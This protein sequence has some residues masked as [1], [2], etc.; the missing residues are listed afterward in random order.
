MKNITTL[1]E[2]Y[3]AVLYNDDIEAICYVYDEYNNWL[4]FDYNVAT[5]KLY[6]LGYKSGIIK[7]EYESVR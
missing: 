1:I 4:K 6:T 5:K 2:N 3:N 7:I